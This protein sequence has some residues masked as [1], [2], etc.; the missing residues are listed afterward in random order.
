MPP[1][2]RQLK[3]HQVNWAGEHQSREDILTER[4]SQ[5]N[6]FETLPSPNKIS[7]GLRMLTSYVAL[8]ESLH[9]SFLNLA[10]WKMGPVFHWDSEVMIMETQGFSSCSGFSVCPQKSSAPESEEG[11]WPEKEQT[12]LQERPISLSP[13]LR[14]MVSYLFE[15]RF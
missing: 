12:V 1:G 13:P 11:R 14:Y 3:K 5:S 7:G 15:H 6:D 10:K 2:A 4:Y 8:L 9:P